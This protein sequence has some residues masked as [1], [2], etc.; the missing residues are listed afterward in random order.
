M[1]S[2]YELIIR[3]VEALV[4]YIHNQIQYKKRDDLAFPPKIYE[5]IFIEVD[6]LILNTNRNVIIGE[7][8]NPPSSK[9]KYFNNNLEK[10]LNKIKKEK[11]YAF[12]MGDYN[13]NTLT[14]L[15]GNTMQ[16]QEFSN[17]FSTF[18]YHKLINLPTRERNQSSTLLDNIYTNIPDCYD[19]GT[20]GIL[21][22][23]PNQI[24]IQYSRL[25]RVKHY[26]NLLNTSKKRN[27]NK[28]NISKFKKSLSKINW[29]NIRFI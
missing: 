12:L 15:K 9:L 7:I 5:S 19:T 4:S 2:V 1:N 26:P 10:I 22:F 27:H 23:L 25:E 11:K 21:K 16:M 6:K 3:K 13:V 8:Y 29:G 14:E 17:I 24:T 18:Y 20:S 28:Q